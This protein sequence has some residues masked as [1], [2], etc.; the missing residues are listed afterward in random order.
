LQ[1]PRQIIASIGA[2]TVASTRL[3]EL[4]FMAEADTLTHT[5]DGLLDCAIED[6]LDLRFEEELAAASTPLEVLKVGSVE[7]TQT[8]RGK[9]VWTQLN[10]L[11][12]AEGE[13]WVLRVLGRNPQ[14]EPAGVKSNLTDI[15]VRDD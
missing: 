6:G 9:S 4:G 14:V 8:S 2:I 3:R 11:R 13:E 15:E 10:Q 1:N 7:L 5:S 12:T